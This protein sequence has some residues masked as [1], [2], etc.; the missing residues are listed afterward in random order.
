MINKKNKKNKKNIKIIGT[1]VGIIAIIII[2]VYIYNQIKISN[3]LSKLTYDI[4]QESYDNCGDYSKSKYQDIVPENI[5]SSMN[6]LLGIE[7]NER[8]NIR[9]VKAYHTTPITLILS[10]ITAKSLYTAEGYYIKENE[11]HETGGKFSSTVYWKLDDDNVW[12]VSDFDFP[13]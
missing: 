10:G 8:N 5:Y 11:D 9:I 7:K 6:Y 3:Y 4:V 12:R 13:P 1:I 2:G